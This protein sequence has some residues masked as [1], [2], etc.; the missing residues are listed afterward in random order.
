MPLEILLLGP[1]QLLEDGAPS[2]EARQTLRRRERAA[3]YLLAA[4]TAPISRDRLLN[5]LW[6]IDADPSK[7]TSALSTTLSRLRSVVP[8]G[9]LQRTN[10]GYELVD[11]PDLFIDYRAFCAVCQHEL[12]RARRIPPQEPLGGAL[13]ARL[14][15]ALALWRGEF[16]EGFVPPKGAPEYDD[17]IVTT[18]NYLETHYLALLSRLAQHAFASQDYPLAFSLASRALERYPGQPEMLLLALRALRWQGLTERASEFLRVMRARYLETAGQDYDSE[19][20]HLAHNLLKRRQRDPKQQETTPWKERQALKVPFVGRKGLLNDLE[21]QAQKGGVALILGDTG[22]GK[23]RLLQEFIQRVRDDHRVVTTVCHHGERALPFAPLLGA[24]RRQ[25][26]PEEWSQVPEPWWPYLLHLFPEAQR[27]LPYVPLEHPPAPLQS[28]LMEVLRQILLVMAREAP[29]VLCVDDA[30]WSDAATVEA[31]L[32]FLER[33]PFGQDGHFMLI[34]ARRE[35]FRESPLGERLW[36]LVQEGNIAT[37]TLE[38]LTKEEVAILAESVLARRLDD[39]EAENLW[40]SAVA[41]TPLYVLEMLRHQV[42]TGNAD[43]PVREWPMAHRLVPLLEQRLDQLPDD[44]R[45]VLSYAALQESSFP[46]QVLKEATGLDEDRLVAA[47]EGLEAR[48]WI[49]RSDHQSGRIL[50]TFVHDKLREVVDRH[51]S[52][53]RRQS[54]HGKLAQAWETVL[55]DAAQSRAAV[56]ARHYQEAGEA[57]R[58]FQWWI[59]SAHHALELGVARQAHDAFYHAERVLFQEDSTAGFDIHEIWALYAEWALLAADTMDCDTLKHIEQSLLRLAELRR[60]PVLRSSALN[61]Q[62]HRL[63]LHDHLAEALDCTQKALR[64]LKSV[65]KSALP[66]VEICTHHATLLYLQGRVGESIECLNKALEIAKDL[67]S[68]LAPLFLGSV[69]YQRAVADTLSFRP[70]RGLQQA[71]KALQAYHASRRVFGVADALGIRSLALFM[72]GRYQEALTDCQE[73]RERAVLFDKRRMLGYLNAYCAFPLSAMGRWAEAWEAANEALTL[74][75][76]QFH[77]A[78]Q[79]LA[80]RIM[81]GMFFMLEDWCTALAYYYESF[82]YSEGLFLRS[83]LLFRLGITFARLGDLPQAESFLACAIKQQEQAIRHVCPLARLSQAEVLINRGKIKEAFAILHTVL[84]EAQEHGR[85]E[86]VCG[87]YFQEARAYLAQGQ[88]VQAQRAARRLVH[89][90]RRIGYV[91]LELQGLEMLQQ[92]QQLTSEEHRR[93]Q[94]LYGYI[95]RLTTHP[96]LGAAARKFLA[97]RGLQEE[98][99]PQPQTL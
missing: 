88:T 3:L 97:K 8:K 65:P 73:A 36:P 23:T 41:G 89:A 51:I 67:D 45:L 58:A 46:W 20:L 83:D 99:L 61:A 74:G 80:L 72:L 50:Y 53:L 37:I 1:P 34:T 71:N 68:P 4:T 86:V 6:G 57:R 24:L 31:L 63:R 79:G 18:S 38:G 75:K 90:S 10:T 26:N 66:Q 44:E 92:M 32:Y 85:E 28:Q 17:W 81:G 62:A 82:Q 84:P 48:G 87:V 96:H 54:I 98:N 76:E 78:A 43:R 95:A 93:L 56:I 19:T 5:M 39:E 35:T 12:P 2:L 7:I 11:H 16:L 64:W 59:A 94:H 21:R 42:E 33:G 60:S 27:Y 47:L 49:Q 40:R 15:Q 55:D 69:Y 91:W 13:A 9:A 52:P 77:N 30:Q 14:Q 25:V 29:L 22:Q 70:D